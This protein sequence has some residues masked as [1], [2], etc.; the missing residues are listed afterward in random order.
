MGVHNPPI[1]FTLDIGDEVGSGTSGS[2]LFVDSSGNLAEDNSNL[3]WDDGND[4][5]GIGTDSPSYELDV[6]DLSSTPSTM[7]RIGSDTASSSFGY[8]SFSK[9]QT[10]DSLNRSAQLTIAAGAVN[11]IAEINFTETQSLRD[12]ATIRAFTSATSDLRFLVGGDEKMRIEDGGNV[13]IGTSSPSNLLDVDG[14]ISVI[15]QVTGTRRMALDYDTGGGS[16]IVDSTDDLRLGTRSTNVLV[17]DGDN[18]VEASTL[19]L[20]QGQ[21]GIRQNSPSAMLDIVN[22]ASTDIG[23]EINGAASQSANLTEWK[24]SGGTTLS[25]VNNLGAFSAPDRNAST[26]SYS[27]VDDPDSGIYRVSADKI[28]FSAGGTLIAEW[29]TFGFFIKSGLFGGLPSD[30]E[31]RPSFGWDNDIDTGMYRPDADQIG[32]ST[33]G[34]ERLKIENTKITVADSIDIELNATTGTKLG[35]ATTQKLGLWNA[36]PVVQPSSTGETLGFTAGSGT[37]VNDDSTFTGNVG[38]TAYRINDIVKHL[39]NIGVLAA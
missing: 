28:G 7:I 30:T 35:T 4:K 16:I 9:G 33:G 38:T 2:V 13:G 12:I 24:N 26:P 32:F 14:T 39:K 3:F 27:F 18:T 20:N 10:I 6:V 34:T 23:L 17:I 8:M 21:V 31:T 5:L 11:R 36:T 25:H 1:A 22:G 15:D 37:A 19:V 29:S